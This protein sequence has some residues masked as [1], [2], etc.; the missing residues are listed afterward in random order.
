M[1]RF[2]KGSVRKC[3]GRCLVFGIQLADSSFETFG[4]LPQWAHW[5]ECPEFGQGFVKVPRRLNDLPSFTLVIHWEFVKHQVTSSSNGSC[6]SFF[7]IPTI[8]FSC[9]P[10]LYV[11][12]ATE[13]KEKFIGSMMLSRILLMYF[14]FRGRMGEAQPHLATSFS[15]YI[16]VNQQKAWCK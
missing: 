6:N 4:P 9:A 8:L 14:Y 1:Q 2:Q 5:S 7:S 13:L 10:A 15:D 12:L 3:R 16:P 11:S